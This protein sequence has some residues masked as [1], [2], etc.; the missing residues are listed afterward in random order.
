MEIYHFCF[1]LDSTKGGVPSGILLSAVELTKHGINSRIFSA[2]NTKNQIS[3]NL[4]HLANLAKT[5]VEFEYSLARI[6]NSYGI[7]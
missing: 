1:A 3:K 6:E 7:G 5:G 4:P 2:G